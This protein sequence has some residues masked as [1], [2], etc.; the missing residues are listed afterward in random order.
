MRVQD[1]FG[2]TKFYDFHLLSEMTRIGQLVTDNG[3]AW[4]QNHIN[5]YRDL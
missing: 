3:L 4:H 2:K 1:F 5:I